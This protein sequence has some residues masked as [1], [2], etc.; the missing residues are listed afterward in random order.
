MRFYVG[1][2][3]IVICLLILAIPI[4][5]LDFTFLFEKLVGTL[6]LII[7]GLFLISGINNLTI[8]YTKRKVLNKGY[9][10]KARIVKV[11]K[12]LLA[13]KSAPNYIL[14][15][16]YE[17]PKNHKLYHTFLDYYASISEEKNI[18]ENQYIEIVID[19]KNPDFVLQKLA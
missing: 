6:L 5:F 18:S 19:P 8:F 15:V 10:T 1:I 12:T 13:I 2:L 4:F 7:S 17:H 16:I 14:E 9:K 3:S 11:Q